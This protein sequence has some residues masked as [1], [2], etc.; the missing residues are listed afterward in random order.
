MSNR[1][2]QLA[3][4]VDSGIVVEHC[5]LRFVRRRK[6]ETYGTGLLQLVLDF[7]L[8]RPPRHLPLVLEPWR[9]T[10]EERIELM[11][12]RLE[13]GR[14]LEALDSCRPRT[15]ADC[16]DVP[17]PCPFVSCRWNLYLD[18]DEQGRI[19][20]PRPDVNVEER[21]DSCALDLIERE[22]DGLDASDAAAVMGLSREQLARIEERGKEAIARDRELADAHDREVEPATVPT[23]STSRHEAKPTPTTGNVQRRLS[24]ALRE[25]AILE[26]L[27]SGP[28]TTSEIV[29]AL[30][31]TSTPI[32]TWWARHVLRLLRSREVVTVRSIAVVGQDAPVHEW[33]CRQ[34]ES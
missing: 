10:S 17:R 8:R 26:V 13:Y 6:G 7:T 28:K 24:A 15:R 31:S 5:R 12:N 33:R 16:A 19:T 20:I 25:R 3:L 21:A 32:G 14:E 2:A 27:A 34:G 1:A 22:P 23:R 4:F 30:A 29:A 18:V 11:K 9:M